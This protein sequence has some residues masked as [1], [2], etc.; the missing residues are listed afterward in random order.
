MPSA[1]KERSK[2]KKLSRRGKHPV[3]EEM[4][5]SAA[6]IEAANAVSDLSTGLETFLAMDLSTGDGSSKET[7][8]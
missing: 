3:S 5:A 8:E 7:S 1:K 4:A 6:R 2:K